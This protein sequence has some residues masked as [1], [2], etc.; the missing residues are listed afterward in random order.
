M[1]DL[2]LVIP[3]VL[4][5]AWLALVLSLGARD[6]LDLKAAAQSWRRLQ[7]YRPHRF[8]FETHT[9]RHWFF[10]IAEWATAAAVLAGVLIG[11]PWAYPMWGSALA[12]AVVG[13]AAHRL[14]IRPLRKAWLAE[15]NSVYT[16]RRGQ[17]LTLLDA[18]GDLEEGE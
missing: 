17:R 10:P 2:W 4:I 14:R 15:T 1:T 7:V 18:S 8:A 3:A 16:C 9:W 13:V 12:V 5:L 11:T 6:E